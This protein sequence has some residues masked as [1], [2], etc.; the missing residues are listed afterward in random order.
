MQIKKCKNG[1]ELIDV[2]VNV[3]LVWKDN[4]GFVPSNHS[5]C[6]GA[7]DQVMKRL[8]NNG[9]AEAYCQ[10]WHDQESAG[11]IERFECHPS[12]YHSYKWLP[13]RP[14]FKLDDQSTTKI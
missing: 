1:I 5:I 12:E 10:Y 14:V 6:L 13:H 4:I 3:E 7:L 2:K 8:E 9:Q 11:Y